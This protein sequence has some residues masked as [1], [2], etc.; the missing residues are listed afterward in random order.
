MFETF[1][2]E[3]NSSISTLSDNFE[4]FSSYF[5]L[6]ILCLSNSFGL[7]LLF[8][9][10]SNKFIMKFD[11]S[12]LHDYSGVKSGLFERVFLKISVNSFP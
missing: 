8:W 1:L 3:S 11:R 2:N 12:E 9:S 4:Y 6:K 5:G 7:D 10:F